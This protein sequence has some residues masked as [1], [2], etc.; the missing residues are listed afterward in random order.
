MPQFEEQA[1]KYIDSVDQTIA[2]RGVMP[3][4]KLFLQS[5]YRLDDYR[6]NNCLCE[7]E[8]LEFR[9]LADDDPYNVRFLWDMSIINFSRLIKLTLEGVGLVIP[10]VE[11]PFPCLKKLNL[12]CTKY[13]NP[14]W[15]TNLIQWCPVVE[16]LCLDME[17]FTCKPPISPTSVFEAH[18]SNRRYYYVIQLLICVSST[19][20]LR[21]TRESL[22]T[23][24]VI[25]RM[26]GI[27]LLLFPNL[28]KLEI[29]WVQ[30]NTLLVLLNNMPNLEYLTFFDGLLSY[31][32]KWNP[33][34]EEA[35]ACLRFK[36]KEIFAVSYVTQKEFAI[37]SYLLKHANNL[38]KLS[39][40]K[41][42]PKRRKRWL[43]IL[44][45]SKYCRIEFV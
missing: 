7:V 29:P 17:S 32:S 44:R 45:A 39:I 27:N 33:P 12:R 16:E 11:I 23:L 1:N 6:V 21:L 8:E 36:L 35:P 9:F 42:D 22:L 3:I 26:F 18:I 38:E 13:L 34:K 25:G 24:D 43:N 4:K 28:A 40:G 30:K 37:V 19:K 2:L 20:I 5:S 15:L 41:V 31:I 14:I 10:E